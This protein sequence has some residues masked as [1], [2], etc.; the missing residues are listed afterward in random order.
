M[1]RRSRSDGGA[2]LVDLAFEPL[3]VTASDALSASA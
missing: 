2:D 3:Y 1:E